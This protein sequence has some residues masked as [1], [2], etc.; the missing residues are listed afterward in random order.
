MTVTIMSSQAN[1][2]TAVKPVDDLMCM[3]LNMS[4]EDMKIDA[5]LPPEYERPSNTSKIVGNAIATVFVVKPG[6][7]VNG[8]VE[9]VRPNWQHAWI[10]KDVL[11]PHVLNLPYETKCSAALMSDGRLGFGNDN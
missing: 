9:V 7:V 6:K 1:A 11:K 5:N 3:D 8:F 2:L 10:K 4:Y